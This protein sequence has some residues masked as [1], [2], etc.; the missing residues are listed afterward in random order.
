LYYT[1]A[2]EYGISS[3]DNDAADLSADDSNEGNEISLSGKCGENLT[4]EIVDFEVTAEQSSFHSAFTGHKLIISGTGD[5]YDYDEENPAPW[6]GFQALEIEEGVTS[7]GNYAFYNNIKEQVIEINLPD[8]LKSIGDFAFS[9]ENIL[10]DSYLQ[11][12]TIP[13]NVSYIGKGAFN[14]GT[15]SW[16]C[17]WENFYVSPDNPYYCDV[18]GIIYTKD[19]TTLV[20]CP[21]AKD[22]SNYVFPEGLLYIGDY[23][24]A[25]NCTGFASLNLPDDLLGIGERAFYNTAVGSTRTLILPKNVSVDNYAF[26]S[27]KCNLHSVVVPANASITRS[28]FDYFIKVYGSS[29]IESVVLDG[30][31]PAYYNTHFQSLDSD[32]VFVLGSNFTAEYENISTRNDIVTAMNTLDISDYVVYDITLQNED[33][34]ETQPQTAVTVLASIGSL[35]D[36]KNLHV[37]RLEEDGSLTDMNASVVDGFAVFETDHFSVYVLAAPKDTDTAESTEA[38]TSANETPSTTIEETGSSL[39]NDVT[40]PLPEIDAEEPSLETD[41]TETLPETDAAESALET[42][43]TEIISS[44]E[45]TEVS[46]KPEESI[47]SIESTSISEEQDQAANTGTSQ[48]FLLYL[49]IILSIFAF[50]S[51]LVCP[52]NFFRK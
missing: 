13:R 6:G 46:S 52:Q 12:L 38:E 51:L 42:D 9:H 36:T 31:D 43:P 44:D 1:Y 37:Y 7:I 25:Y 20:A 50:L 32:D 39:E 5:M 15:K 17:M 21:E 19:M 24:F 29:D 33:G 8:S 22:L 28:S 45:H 48:T 10:S 14:V 35:T 3:S 4:Y 34:E 40:E 41:I 18:D 23:A 2:D 47:E 30:Y 27:I 11:E 49:G 16:D 26:G